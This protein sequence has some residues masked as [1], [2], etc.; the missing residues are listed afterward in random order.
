MATSR[1]TT[2]ADGP[3]WLFWKRPR[4]PSCQS[5]RLLANRSENNGDGTVTRHVRCADC[6]ER[7]RLVLE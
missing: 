5:V 6:G 3:A 2:R 4:C 1:T 7:L